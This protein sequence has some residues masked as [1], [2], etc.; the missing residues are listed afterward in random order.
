MGIYM[1]HAQVKDV[2]RII[3]E[4]I[5]QENEQDLKTVSDVALTYLLKR[6]GYSLSPNLVCFYRR[7]IGIP[8]VP[9]RL[10][11]L[12]KELPLKKRNRN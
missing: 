7:Q 4:T 5:A 3:A 9:H 12:A 1:T 11:T 10:R 8:G 6:N 2:K